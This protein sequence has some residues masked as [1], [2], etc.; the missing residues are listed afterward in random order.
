[1]DE[2]EIEIEI[3]KM[4]DN[5]MPVSPMRLK[6]DRKEVF[7]IVKSMGSKCLVKYTLGE[8]SPAFESEPENIEITEKGQK[9]LEL[10]R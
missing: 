8:E 2:K 10:N 3:L 5:G 6:L 7:R 1:M 9:Y 4:L